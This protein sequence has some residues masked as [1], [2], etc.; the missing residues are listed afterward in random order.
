MASC[1][2]GAG[3]AFRYRLVD[4][5][6]HDSAAQSRDGSR[7]SL[8]DTLALLGAHR[9]KRGLGAG[10][11]HRPAPA[12]LLPRCAFWR[13]SALRLLQLHGRCCGRCLQARLAHGHVQWHPCGHCLH[14]AACGWHCCEDGGQQQLAALHL[15]PCAG[16]R[17]GLHLRLRPGALPGVLL[18]RLGP[19]SHVATSPHPEVPWC[20]HG[21]QRNH[22]HLHQRSSHSALAYVH[23]SLQ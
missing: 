4:Q 13:R 12:L 23:P 22:G 15:W 1:A 19:A 3:A 10:E 20:V 2:W 16:C 11:H 6:L 8:Q 17:P 7:R 21:A 9:W 18:A 5:D 14:W